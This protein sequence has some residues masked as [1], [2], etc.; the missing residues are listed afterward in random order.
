MR[1]FLLC[2]VTPTALVLLTIAL[3]DLPVTLRTGVWT[4]LTVVVGHSEAVETAVFPR[5]V[6]MDEVLAGAERVAMPLARLLFDHN[7]SMVTIPAVAGPFLIVM[8]FIKLGAR[9]TNPPSMSPLPT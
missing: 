2:H 1:T 6:C 4:L 7:F 9:L 5:S 8:F 3:P